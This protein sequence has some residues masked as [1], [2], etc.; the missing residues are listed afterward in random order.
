M[1]SKG[2]GY[3]ALRHK[4]FWVISLYKMSSNSLST[5]YKELVGT[6]CS[7]FTLFSNKPNKT[8]CF[9]QHPNMETKHCSIFQFPDTVSQTCKNSEPFLIS[10]EGLSYWEST[11]M[12]V[13]SR[14]TLTV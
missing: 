9:D 6:S 14:Q 7:V 2:F 11:V 13:S 10:L 1:T 8:H 5:V 12:S 4:K 3:N